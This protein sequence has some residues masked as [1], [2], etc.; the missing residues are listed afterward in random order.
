[1][2]RLARGRG[3]GAGRI[4]VGLGGCGAE[5]QQE[6]EPEECLHHAGRS[7]GQGRWWKIFQVR[8]AG[9]GEGEY[10]HCVLDR[11]KSDLSHETA[12]SGIRGGLDY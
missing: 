8:R 10:G 7:G 12:R 4:V 5:A 3:G 2:V 6:D 9:G 11:R 1:M